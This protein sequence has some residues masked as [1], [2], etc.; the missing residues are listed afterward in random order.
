MT[1][2]ISTPQNEVPEHIIFY[3]KGKLM[4][5]YHRDNHIEKTEVVL[6]HQQIDGINEYVCEVTLNLYG[7]TVMI[8]RSSKSYLQAIRQVIKEIS[9]VVEEFIEH[10]NDLPD[11]IA[12]TVMV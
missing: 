8:H 10:R 12:T 4:N 6:R 2:E 3:L 5:F 9:K 7:E 1:I 11:K